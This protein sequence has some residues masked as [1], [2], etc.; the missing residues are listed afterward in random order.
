MRFEELLNISAYLFVTDP[1]FQKITDA[2]GCEWDQL[3][4]FESVKIVREYLAKRA[5]GN[6]AEALH[7]VKPALRILIVTDL[8][9]NAIPHD[10]DAYSSLF[11]R[12]IKAHR[13]AELGKAL[14]G[15]PEAGESL[16]ND[17]SANFHGGVESLAVEDF[18]PIAFHEKMHA[19]KS[20]K[21]IIEIPGFERLSK[22]IG[23]FN[24]GRLI[25]IM[26]ETGF[27]KT[28]IA[29]NLLLRAALNRQ[30]AYCNMEM[31]PEDIA[32]RMV[33]IGT[34]TPYEEFYKGNVS[35]KKV[36]EMVGHVAG[37]I[38]MTNGRVLTLPMIKA[39][40]KSLKKKPE[41]VVVDYDQKIKLRMDRNTPQW[42]A[43]QDAI[44]ELE[45]LAK[46][47][48]FC[49]ILLAQ[50]N[51]DGDI[52]ASH[53]ATFTAHTVLNFRDD[54]QHGAIIEAKKNRHGEQG[55]T[56]SV[57][58]QKGMSTVFEGELVTLTE[59]KQ[60]FKPR[61]TLSKTQKN[62]TPYSEGD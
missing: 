48:G 13:Y 4:N 44:I 32:A 58:Y 24:P 2:A 25:M 26:A 45:D 14:L 37:R 34:S 61:K 43:I 41:F 50:V 21:A 46:E 1:D 11:K 54:A 29:L 27:G 6:H 40:L 42:Q 9:F 39:W 18:L 15:S 62:F 5:I 3:P 55:A 19:I 16:I 49:L 12:T 51:R 30:T 38:Q 31:V 10:V 22:M 53:R 60:E 56:L 36:T 52:S 47:M 35:E 7:S 17:F 20:G 57:R 59:S 23:G 28:N 8:N 33:V